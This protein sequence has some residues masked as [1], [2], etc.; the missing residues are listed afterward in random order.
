LVPFQCP[1]SARDRPEQLPRKPQ[2]WPVAVQSLQ[3]LPKF[4]QVVSLDCMHMPF[5]QQPVKQLPA[6]Q[7]PE[8]PL[9]EPD[10]D[11]LDDPDE[12]PLDEPEDDPDELP[13]DEPDMPTHVPIEP[14]VWF[15]AVQSTHAAPFVPHAVLSL[16]TPQW[17]D[18]SQH[19]LQIAAHPLASSLLASSPG[20]APLLL[21]L[22]LVLP[23]LLLLPLLPL[24]LRPAP[25]DDEAEASLGTPASC[26]GGTTGPACVPG[27][28]SPDV[29]P[30]AQATR[31]TRT[32]PP[33]L[34]V[35]RFIEPM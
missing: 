35:L 12:L 25:P 34:I 24:L 8:L 7:W 4:P 1:A 9:D 10:D 27:S 31:T 15:V 16:P 19:P 30:V 26:T 18:R 5:W 11:P 2:V 14:H 29:L 32:P 3:E 23:P 17:P 6:L 13:L 22:L 21:V 28:I 33:I 20:A